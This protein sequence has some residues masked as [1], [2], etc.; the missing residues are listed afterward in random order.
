[1]NSDCCKPSPPGLLSPHSPLMSSSRGPKPS[2]APKPKKLFQNGTPTPL[3]QGYANGS[4]KCVFFDKGNGLKTQ[5]VVHIVLKSDDGNHIDEDWRL[6]TLTEKTDSLETL[7]TVEEMPQRRPVKQFPFTEYYERSNRKRA[8]VN[9]TDG[10]VD[11]SSLPGFE[12]K[13][14]PMQ[15]ETESAY[16]EAYNV[17]PVAVA[18]V[19]DEDQGRTSE[20]DCVY[21]R[22]PDG[23]SRA[24]Y[25]A[26]ELLDT[27]R[28][29]IKVLKLLHEDFR[30]AV[31]SVVD[32]EMKP[33]MEEDRLREILIE[34][35]DV[36]NLHRRI[37]CELEGRVRLW[38]DSQK[39][40]D[41]FLS[42]KSEF[43]VFTTF[44]GHY[45]RSVALLEE[46]CRTSPRLCAV[47]Q[48]FEN[49]VKSSLKHQL[50]QVV[51]RV[52]QY[53]MLLT[54][55]LN[56]LSPDSQEYEDTQ[57]AV[58]IVSD[59]AY[60]A[61]DSLENGENLLRL[62]N[63]DYSV[64]GQS[65]LLQPGRVFIK[66]GTLMK[67]SRK[68]R[69]PRHL[70]LMNDI[71]L[72]TFPQQDGKYR[73]KNTLSLDGLKVTKPIVDEVQ[74]ALRIDSE[75]LSI[76]LSASSL[77][78]REE[79][80]LTLSHTVSEHARAPTDF[81]SS[82]IYPSVNQISTYIHK[83]KSSSYQ[84][85]K[86]RI[87]V[88]EYQI[89]KLRE[90]CART[91]ITREE[92]TTSQQQERKQQEKSQACA[93]KL[94]SEM[95]QDF[96]S[97]NEEVCDILKDCV[98]KT[99]EL[100]YKAEKLMEKVVAQEQLLEKLQQS[101]LIRDQF[102]AT[103]KS[104]R[105]ELEE[106]VNTLRGRNTS[107][108][109]EMALKDQ[110]HV[111]ERTK[112]TK[113]CTLKV[114]ALQEQME[115]L[116]QS[117]IN[118]DQ[119]I[120][121]NQSRTLELE[122]DRETLSDRITSL[123]AEMVHKDQL[124]VEEKAKISKDCTLKVR[125]LQEQMEGLQQSSREKDEMISSTQSRM[126]ELEN[127]IKA[128][129]ESLNLATELPFANTDELED[130]PTVDLLRVH[131]HKLQKDM[132]T[133]R[134][135]NS[136]LQAEM[137]FKEQSSVEE[138][139][140]K[141]KEF[142]LERSNLK[143]QI[144]EL[145]QCRLEKDQTICELSTK[146]EY[147]NYQ[148]TELEDSPVVVSLRECIHKLE[149][150]VNTLSDRNISLTAEMVHKDQLYVEE[151]TK[152]SND[153]I[154]KVSMLQEQMEGLQE[155]LINKD[156]I[157]AANQSRTLELELD[158]ETLSDRIT[159]LTAEMVHKDQL[160]VEEKAKI[161]K[162]CTL[163]VRALQE[164]ME[165]LQQSSREKDEMIASTQSRMLELENNI[166]A[167]VESLNLATEL[168]FANT[169]ELEDNPTVDL[170]RVHIHKLQK[171]M[172]TLRDRNSSLQAEMVF[173]DQSSVEEITKITKDYTLKVS[174]LQEQMEGLQQSLIDKD[175]IITTNQSL[176][177]DFEIYRKALQDRITSLTAEMVFKDQSY[178][179]ENTKKD[180]ENE[181]FFDA[182]DFVSEEK[183]VETSAYRTIGKY[184]IRGLIG[185]SA[186]TV[187]ATG[188]FLLGRSVW[189][190]DACCYCG[191]DE[192]PAFF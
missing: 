11:M 176:M 145:H 172:K 142:I 99:R 132:K 28:K 69:Q 89:G 119:I 22:Q 82:F 66:E 183:G 4:L 25:V 152:I 161:S 45:D 114:T 191:F 40:A 88:L 56:N 16:T 97:V 5:D 165:G 169:D 86:Y 65:D 143:D 26:K 75:E 36:Y 2:V 174:S 192:T 92:Q 70:F 120:A 46:S 173:K 73:L 146:L 157:I 85:D 109:A 136:S 52:A 111:E 153:C 159:S 98:V 74:N 167:E 103:S 55:Y 154:S 185:L 8:T 29:H 149:M 41:I 140:K 107:L 182:L 116:Q 12:K 83:S 187:S 61:N 160:Y 184:L 7:D 158:R 71:L 21:E 135:R 80:F 79:W 42:R 179:E 57:A 13:M 186:V 138:I 177:S 53:R 34:L 147:Q 122:L 148:L 115:G 156:Q 30:E 151:M 39:M 190:E 3:R 181:S 162:D 124:Y 133:L 105:L 51:V 104:K 102:I 15:D 43:L 1:M 68:S 180:L 155:S 171:D 63:I 131:I 32:A 47:V 100:P 84:L 18:P 64:R 110:G 60:Q 108:T 27:E 178:Q 54:D 121:A 175:K 95:K 150:D 38:S 10:Y 19:R 50:L 163:K 128:E 31:M 37:L 117:L 67:V 44:I 130:N 112:I 24:Y 58:T 20:E 87:N 164:Q 78:E 9:D 101:F 6:S 48:D 188:G 14:Q 90:E 118:K 17:C 129:V 166:K 49:R 144:K 139:T 134:D 33:V 23:H 141:S 77:V 93:A 123:T 170:L 59:I 189:S 126:L 81:F 125:A 76:T 35:P 113:D 137:V 62:V 91:H 96:N 127:N 94:L 72:Y 168:P 106:E